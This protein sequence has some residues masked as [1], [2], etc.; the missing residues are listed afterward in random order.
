MLTSLGYFKSPDEGEKQGGRT[1]KVTT[2]KEG[3]VSVA[4]DKIAKKKGAPITSVALAY[5]THKGKTLSG[6]L[7]RLVRLLT[8]YQRPTSSQS[9]AAAKSLI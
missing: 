5:V 8:T 4:L 6:H 7:H 3:S 9:S 1:L 2:G